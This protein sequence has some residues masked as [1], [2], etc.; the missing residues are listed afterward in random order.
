[1]NLLRWEK[2]MTSS[3]AGNFLVP[4]LS[5]VLALAMG[6][7]FLA[8]MGY[9]PLVIYREMFTSAFFSRYGLSETVV[10]TIPLMLTGLGVAVAFRMLLWN[11]GAEGQL[12]MGAFAASWVALVF[13]E[14]PA[15]LLLPGMFIAG[16]AGGAL[17]GLLPAIPRALMGVNETITTLLLNYVAILWVDYLVYGPWKD[18]KGFNFPLTKPFSE[19]AFLPTLGNTRVHL[20]LAFGLVAAVVLYIILRRTRW[21]FEV[22]VIG[23]S[24]AAARYAGMDITR[25]I[26]LVMM[27]SGGLAGLAGMSEVAGI[28]HRLQHGFSPGYGYTAIIVAWLAKLHPGAV[29]LVS[30]LLG[31]LLVG[32]YSLQSSGL[33]A[34]TVSMLQG[35]IL[36]FLLGG[37]ILTRYRLVVARKGGD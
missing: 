24:S 26:L 12:Y 20:G 13:P 3:R 23:E 37:E 4:V 19:A 7:I 32:G 5:I 2:R 21:G 6:G 31:G 8:A 10:K 33:P 27:V 29:V 36:F 28:T 35:A 25:N 22:R 9:K 14:A 15:Y 30:F 34:A 16:F 18:P 17:W 1:M 11:I